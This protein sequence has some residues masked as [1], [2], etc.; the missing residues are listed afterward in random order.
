MYSNYSKGRGKVFRIIG[1]ACTFISAL[2]HRDVFGSGF[3]AHRL[4]LPCIQGVIFEPAFGLFPLGIML[5]GES[6]NPFRPRPIGRFGV[7]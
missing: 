3:V 5:R 6:T 4:H 1:L 7:I 2:L